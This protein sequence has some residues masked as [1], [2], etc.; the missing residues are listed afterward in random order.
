MNMK[1][2]YNHKE[3]AAVVRRAEEMRSQAIAAFV[4]GMVARVRSLFQTSR[5]VNAH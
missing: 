4:K 3:I 2:A 1:T 5:P